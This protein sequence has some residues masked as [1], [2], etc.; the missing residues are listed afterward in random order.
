MN[1]TIDYNLEA[2]LEYNK[3]E[4]SLGDIREV[5]A[6]Y[7]GSKDEE[8]WFWILRLHDDSCWL[9]DGWCD[10][11]GWDCQSGAKANRLL[12]P[13]AFEGFMENWR[14]YRG[15][16]AV[17]KLQLL[18][19]KN[20]TWRENMDKVFMPL[21]AHNISTP[22]TYGN[23][24]VSRTHVSNLFEKM[25]ALIHV[26]VWDLTVHTYRNAEGIYYVLKW[27]WPK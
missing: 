11:T 18:E 23:S 15:V 17:L 19:G 12:A 1:N 2:C 6:V 14:Q 7:E 26:G 5:L 3:V 16:K 20:Q 27:V 10:Y 13:E 25:K 21:Q 4:F 9:L 22:D 8:N 24:Y